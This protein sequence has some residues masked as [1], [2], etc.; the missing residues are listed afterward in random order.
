MVECSSR[1]GEYVVTKSGVDVVIFEQCWFVEG[2]IIVWCWK[3]EI[4]G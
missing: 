1:I 3:N 2:D 4:H